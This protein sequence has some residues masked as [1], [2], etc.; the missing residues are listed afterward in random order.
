M[1]RRVRRIG[2]P[3]G[4]TQPGDAMSAERTDMHLLQELVRLHR[5][6]ITVRE[7]ARTLGISPNTERKYRMALK[8]SGLLEG[9][10]SQLPELEHIH[11]ILNEAIPPRLPSQQP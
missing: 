6:N 7:I 10:P 11:N 1:G 9:D 3:L 4:S 5:M 2:D 8:G